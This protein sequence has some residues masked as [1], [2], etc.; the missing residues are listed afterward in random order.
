[1]AFPG[2]EVI[3]GAVTVGT[4]LLGKDAIDKA[5]KAEEKA[6]AEAAALIK[7]QSDKTQADLEPW[8]QAG[9]NALGWLENANIPGQMTGDEISEHLKSTPG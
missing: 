2:E 6:A 1:M 4:V 9:V 8:R 3:N 5:T 7:T